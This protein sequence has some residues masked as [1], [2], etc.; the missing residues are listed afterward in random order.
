MVIKVGDSIPSGV[1]THV[2]YT[3]ELDDHS[4]CGKPIS[5]DPAEA[6]KG[7]KVILVSVPGAFTPG[8]HMTHLPPYIEKFEHLKE[9]HKVDEIAIVA[10]NDAFV[11]SAWG[12]VTGGA[13]KGVLFLSDNNAEYASK[14]GLNL[15]GRGMARTK[16]FAIV[17]NDN[18]VVYVG[19]DE[20]GVDQSGV[21]AVMAS[22]RLHV[23]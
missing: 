20:T 16:R 4:V 11:M 9:E 2:P 18:K 22:T 7:K 23:A 1:L 19:I 17:I 8:C 15:D 10:G 12:R 6:W 13:R 14:M 5:F 3:P 21:E